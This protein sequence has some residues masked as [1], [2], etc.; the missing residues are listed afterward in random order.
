MDMLK[1]LNELMK[2]KS[3]SEDRACCKEA[4]RYVMNLA[5]DFGFETSIGH[6]AEKET[7]SHRRYQRRNSVDRYGTL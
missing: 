7:A 5:E 2:F 3:V 1:H 4:L 6:S